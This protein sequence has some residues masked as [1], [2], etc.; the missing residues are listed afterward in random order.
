MEWRRRTLGTRLE[1][2]VAWCL[3]VRRWERGNS[4]NEASRSGWGKRTSGHNASRSGDEGGGPRGT[5]PRGR[6]VGEDL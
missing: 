5:T 4:G 1:E 6:G 3:E 2:L